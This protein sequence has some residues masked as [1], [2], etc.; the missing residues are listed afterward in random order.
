MW[1]KIQESGKEDKMRIKKI[2]DLEHSIQGD[3]KNILIR[4]DLEDKLE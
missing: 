3:L 1:I 2:F 4:E